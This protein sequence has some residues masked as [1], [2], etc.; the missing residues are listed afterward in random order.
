MASDSDRME[1]A[2]NEASSDVI[3]AGF[4]GGL[5]LTALVLILQ[6]SPN[7][8]E[9]P[10]SFLTAGEFFT[11]LVVLFALMVVLCVFASIVKIDVASKKSS[12][13]SAHARRGNNALAGAFFVLLVALPLLLVPFTVVGAAGVGVIEII[14]FAY[15]LLAD[16]DSF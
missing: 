15:I 8:F 7:P 12:P 11:I 16:D 2:R 14:L 6:A 10:V 3:L 9:Q 5:A 13:L 4:F 1:N